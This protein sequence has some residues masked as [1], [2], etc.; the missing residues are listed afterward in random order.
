MSKFGL[1]DKETKRVGLKSVGELLYHL[2]PSGYDSFPTGLNRVS[3]EEMQNLRQALE[4]ERYFSV[5]MGPLRIKE[6]TSEI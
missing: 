6:K 3:V 4:P 1:K 2:N 5:Q